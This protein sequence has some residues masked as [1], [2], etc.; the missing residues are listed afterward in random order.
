MDVKLAQYLDIL[1]R[2]K[3]VISITA[4]LAMIAA[5]VGSS[6]L[7]RT[8]SAT[9]IMRVLTPP[10]GSLARLEFDLRYAD[11]IMATYA[12]MVTSRPVVDQLTERMNIASSPDI[13]VK[14]PA[15]TELMQVI[16]KDENPVLARDTAN[17]LAE[18]LVARSKEL[19]S[20]GG[21]T[22]ADIL[23]EQVDQVETELD[24]ARR[25][26]QVLLAEATPDSQRLESARGAID[27]LERIS[28]ARVEQYEE[29][30]A[31]EIYRSNILSIFEP[32]LTPEHPSGPP[33]VLI[34]GLAA[35]MGLAGG[36]GLAFVFENLDPR[37]YSVSQIQTV[38]RL[39]ILGQ[40]PT[41][42][43]RQSDSIFSHHSFEQEA[44]RRLRTTLLPPN[45][46]QVLLSQLQGIE[47]VVIQRLQDAGIFT[48]EQLAKTSP[49]SIEVLLDGMAAG[50]AD[51][52]HWIEQVRALQLEGKNCYGRPVRTLL[53]T[54][55]EPQEGKSTVVANLA[56]VLAETGR[57]IVI[58]D[59]DL[60]RPTMH[61]LF[62]L[63]NE[64]GLSSVL[65]SQVSS[66]EA[67]QDSDTVGI[68][69]LTSG[70]LSHDS[71][72]CLRIESVRAL[73]HQLVQEF[74][75]VL[76]DSP[77][78]LAV[79][80]TVALAT[81]VDCVV[82]VVRHAHAE[83]TAVKAAL[84]QLANV[85]V[86]PVGVIVNRSKQAAIER[87]YSYYTYKRH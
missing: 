8:Y 58:V 64:L 35:V 71:A 53:V 54:S 44:F 87:C 23:G 77:T 6:L 70:P 72:V 66:I 18:I 45:G 60:W 61:Q 20:G 69:V 50:K 86:E 25:Q 47:P 43:R 7:P 34:I 79:S 12:Q 62:N 76:L 3:W 11:R 81:L 9:V 82:L 85:H 67:L 73:L 19:S 83:E 27:L 38:T 42:K 33:H 55:A 59:G 5:F 13:H 39:P 65:N 37:L 24:E 26:Y 40:I 2:R 78:L 49:E 31:A 14:V 56:M 21:K 80:D 1:L 51:A 30:H 36:L 41:A 68:T 75:I 52:A 4:A 28:A 57:R 46:E 29:A 16:V 10:G 15:N 63:S 84:E 32:A 17:T 22:T 74:D 48:C